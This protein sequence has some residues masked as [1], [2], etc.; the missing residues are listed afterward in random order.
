[1]GLFFVEEEDR[2]RVRLRSKAIV[3][4]GIAKEHHGGGHPVAAGATAYSWKE[5]EEIIRKLR[6]A[7]HV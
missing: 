3:I 6:Q 5:V 7:V 1:M 4:N 2:I